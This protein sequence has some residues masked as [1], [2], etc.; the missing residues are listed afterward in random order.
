MYQ[1][2]YN[3]N[4]HYNFYSSYGDLYCWNDLFQQ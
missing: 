1:T 4:N 2:R 3:E